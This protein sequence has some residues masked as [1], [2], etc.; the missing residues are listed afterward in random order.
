MSRLRVGVVGVGALGQ[1]HARI[2]SELPEVELVA[3]V[4]SQPTRGQE[5]AARCRT[6]WLPDPQALIGEVDAVSVVV[7]TVAHLAVAADFL[8]HGVPVLVEKPLAHNVAA[9]R[10]L[11]ELA[12]QSGTLLQVGHIERFNPAW[13]AALPWLESPNYVRT[14]RLAPFSF[15]STDIG[16]VLD[17]MIH[18]LDLLLAVVRCPLRSV[19]AFGLALMG[20]HEDMVQARLSFQNGCIADLS[21]S[22]VHPHPRRSFTAWSRQGCVT[23][24]LHQ[25]TV[26]R[27]APTA[28]LLHGEC[29][30]EL[31]AQP[32]ADLETLKAS[33]FGRWV[34]VS[35]P[36]VAAQDALTAELLA[37]LDCVRTGRRPLVDGETALE[38]LLVADRILAQVACHQWDGH[39]GGAVGPCLLEAPLRGLRKAG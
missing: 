38:A 2:L 6:R 14:E 12:R 1:H 33:V 19:E 10:E 11:V 9:A 25:R 28:A 21:V 39:P 29:P 26:L 32:H 17:L 8:R 7:P 3:V 36:S 16:A 20:P 31:A 34:E 22:R 30:L 13:Q 5:V 15:R 37:F 18:D 27:Y 24:D 4:D 23:I 35:S